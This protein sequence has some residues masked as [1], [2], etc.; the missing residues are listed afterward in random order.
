MVY[1]GFQLTIEAENLLAVG[2][3]SGQQVLTPSLSAVWSMPL[4]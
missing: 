4:G 1:Q 2:Y 3:R